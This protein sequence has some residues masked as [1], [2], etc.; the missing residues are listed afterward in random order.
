VIEVEATQAY[1][2]PEN[3]NSYGVICR[4]QSDSDGYFL[5]ISGDGYYSIAKRVDG[6][7]EYLVK[8]ATSDVIRQ[9]NSTNVIR[10]VCGGPSLI[11]EVNGQVLGETTDSTFTEGDIGLVAGTYEDEAT[12]VH[13]DNLLVT[14]VPSR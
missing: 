10:A 11:L 1:A 8:W 13:F 4:L 3:D 14:A 6:E 12:E 2:G 9:G 5:R 7:Y